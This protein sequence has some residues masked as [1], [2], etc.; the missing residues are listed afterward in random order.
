METMFRAAYTCL[1]RKNKIDILKLLDL[2]AVAPFRI[3]GVEAAVLEEGKNAEMV[4]I[5]TDKES[6]IEEEGFRS[7]SKNSPFLGQTLAS[8]IICTISRG[9]I[10]FYN[11]NRR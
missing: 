4:L 10:A 7:R 3:L 9:K 2:L 1:C 6:V 11:L 5:D 8:E